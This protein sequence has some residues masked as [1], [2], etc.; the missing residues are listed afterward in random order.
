[1]RFKLNI[2]FH[3]SNDLANNVV[4][5]QIGHISRCDLNEIVLSDFLLRAKT[6]DLASDAFEDLVGVREPFHRPHAVQAPAEGTEHIKLH[7]LVLHPFRQA[8]LI[9]VQCR[10]ARPSS[11]YLGRPSEHRGDGRVVRRDERGDEL[12][13]LLRA[14]PLVEGQQGHWEGLPEDLAA[15]R[16]DDEVEGALDALRE[17]AEDIRRE[18]RPDAVRRER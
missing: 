3:F 14:H 12:G 13:T 2:K 8:G 16:D 18:D 5:K 11:E 6:F 17:G 1:M 10:A 9:A 4:L 15:A 7:Y